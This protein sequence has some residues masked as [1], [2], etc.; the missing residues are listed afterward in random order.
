M[1]RYL[2]LATLLLSA[3]VTSAQEK[4]PLT[5]D[6]AAA[7]A[8]QNS[9][10]IEIS[11][12]A[13]DASHAERRVINGMRLPKISLDASY[14]YMSD[15]IAFDLNG[16]KNGTISAVGSLLDPAV[17]AE[18]MKQ[19]LMQEIIAADFSL[20]LQDRDFAIVGF[21]AAM[22]LYT[23]GKINVAS[24]VAKLKHSAEQENTNKVKDVLISE[25]VES[26]YGYMLAM[27]VV[28]TRKEVLAGMELHLKNAE[29]LER[30]G[31]IAKVERLH[32]QMYVSNAKRDLNIS[33]NTLKTL[34]E[35]LG[36]TLGDINA[37]Y[38]PVSS[39]FIIGEQKPIDHFKQ[40]ASHNNHSIK[41]LKIQE[42]IAKQ[43]IKL[44]KS[45]YLPE[46]VALGGI[47]AYSYQLTSMVPQW[48][49]GAGL[50]FNIF[51]G[52]SRENKVRAAKLRQKQ[53]SIL[54]EKAQSDVQTLV[55]K[56]Y[57]DMK[58]YV[59]IIESLDTTIEFN[60]EYLRVKD[61][62]F[63]EGNATSSQVVDARL[64][65]AVSKVERLQAAYGY[66]VAY[67]KLLE[68]CGDSAGFLSLSS[69]STYQPI[70]FQPN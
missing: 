13:T 45:A 59:E 38:M 29:S 2:T 14:T 34:S 58:G 28:E 53:V 25:L 3:A 70:T 26:Y 62:A 41:Q 17:A 5:I 7:I 36:N 43:G 66:S 18:L 19:P 24:R 60:R 37:D 56:L 67:A 55:E 16:V 8:I 54:E 64:L 31:M 52:F 1:K 50:K 12:L 47:N 22:P 11:S 61:S 40:L 63:T 49:V 20:P 33:I 46:L 9:K 23:G 35:A 4:K 51:D 15:D 44:E 48:V 6:Q 57:N 30:N 42:E 21:T 68:L 10:M 69:E 39:L 27:Q 65:L 32:A